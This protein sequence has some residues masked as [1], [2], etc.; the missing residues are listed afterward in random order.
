M[1]GYL[2]FDLT[3]NCNLRCIMCQAYNDTPPSALQCANFEAF[4]KATKGSLDKW[5]TIQLGNVA[6]PLINPRFADFLRYIRSETCATIHIVTNGNLLGRYADVINEVG[7]CLIQV[8]VDS[9]NEK[10]HEY[11]RTGS[12][13]NHVFSNI[14]KIKMGSNRV[15]LSFTLMNC[16]I[17]EYPDIIE[18][19]KVNGFL[20]SAFPMMLR[21]HRGVI[22]LQLVKESLWFNKKGLEHWIEAHYGNSYGKTVIGNA[23][24]NRSEKLDEFNCQ[25]HKTDLIVDV[26][27]TASLCGKVSIGSIYSHGLEKAWSCD[28]SNTFRLSV[29]QDRSPC[30]DCDYYKRCLNPSMTLLDNHFSEN[31]VNFL[32]TSTRASISFD[33]KISDAEAMNIFIRTLSKTFGIYEITERENEFEARRVFDVNNFGETLKAVKKHE[34]QK[35]M[36]DQIC[37]PFNCVLVEEGFRGYNIVS[38]MG[39]FWGLPQTLGCLNI[40]QQADREKPGVLVAGAFDELKRI[41]S[42]KNA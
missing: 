37:A 7:N 21:D 3:D 30:M 11:I 33:R 28:Q 4:V 17:G 18:F 40:A 31:I 20:I 10:T 34:L 14:K 26:L 16:N 1:R 12:K 32:D 24:G 29:D 6:E 23:T 15:L 8:S 39:R 2:R 5:G 13:Y 42:E 22:P 36:M 27:G 41:L 9:I 19:C 38:Y 25:A 35:K